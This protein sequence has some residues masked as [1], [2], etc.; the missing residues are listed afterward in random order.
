MGFKKTLGIILLAVP[1][2]FA[3][4]LHDAVLAQPGFDDFYNLEYDRAL[5]AFFEQA[6]Q[7][8]SSPD[9][10]NHIAQTVLYKEMYR[11]GM[12][13]SEFI[14]GTKFTRQPKLKLTDEEE[15][16]F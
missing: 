7:N 4:S 12:L 6:A 2:A 5:A 8:G 11:A 9:A 13:S 15:A 16:Q 10:Y 1:A 14:G 3:G